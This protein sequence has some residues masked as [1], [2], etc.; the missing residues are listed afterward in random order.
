MA[1]SDAVGTWQR[2]IHNT[3]RYQRCQLFY[4]GL[5]AR[6]DM[7]KRALWE[8]CSMDNRNAVPW[9][10]GPDK[11]TNFSSFYRC[12]LAAKIFAS[13]FHAHKMPAGFTLWELSADAARWESSLQLRTFLFPSIK[14][15]SV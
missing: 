3:E 15:S 8:R 6:W 1:S 10:R 12:V 7:A 13:V 9:C 2:V 14:T 5:L 4:R 11:H